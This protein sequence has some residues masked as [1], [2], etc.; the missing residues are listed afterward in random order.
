MN[1]RAVLARSV[2]L[3][4]HIPL[5]SSYLEPG[6]RIGVGIAAD[7]ELKIHIPHKSP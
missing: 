2:D 4:E 5:H 6:Y 1:S 3:P 7:I